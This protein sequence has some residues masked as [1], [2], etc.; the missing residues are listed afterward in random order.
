[1][2][3]THL[4][5]QARA[6]YGGDNERIRSFISTCFFLTL[7]HG[8]LCAGGLLDAHYMRCH[9]QRTFSSI[10]MHERPATSLPLAVVDNQ[11]PS[12]TSFT[13]S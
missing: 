1:M 9:V 13:I 7:Q 4:G 8:L 10:G 6:G 2:S 3:D 5:I 12:F 11:P